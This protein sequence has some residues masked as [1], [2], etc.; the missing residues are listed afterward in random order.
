MKPIE[1]SSKPRQRWLVDRIAG[2]QRK[3]KEATCRRCGARVLRGPDRDRVSLDATVDPRPVDAR[4]EQLA[5]E[6]GRFTYDYILGRLEFRHVERI[7]MSPG[8]RRHQLWVLD[9]PVLIEH[10]CGDLPPAAK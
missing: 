1:E 3:A 5:L 4:G 7:A 9:R 6:Q 8:G 10:R 2:E